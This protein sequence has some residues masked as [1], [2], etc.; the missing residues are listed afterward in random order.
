[1]GD[2]PIKVQHS[3]ATPVRCTI[4]A[5]GAMSLIC[6]RAAQLALTR[7]RA[8]PI[9]LARRST[10]RG[11]ELPPQPRDIARHAWSGSR[12][13]D[14]GRVDPQR[15]NQVEDVDLLLYRRGT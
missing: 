4:S 9:S 14:V 11:P 1:M 12:Q 2:D 8:D 3:M 13:T 6:V 5:I 7:R 15:I 10:P